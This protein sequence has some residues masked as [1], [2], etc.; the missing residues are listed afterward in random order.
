M[1]MR[2]DQQALAALFDDLAEGEWDR[3]DKD[4]LGGVGVQS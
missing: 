4:M 2:Y 1:T 3:F